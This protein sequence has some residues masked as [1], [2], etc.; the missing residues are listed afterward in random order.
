[1]TAG[2]EGVVHCFGLAA[3][4]QR[5]FT[6]DL[7]DIVLVRGEANDGVKSVPWLGRKAGVV[8]GLRGRILK[9]RGWISRNGAFDYGVL[10]ECKYTLTFI[11]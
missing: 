9:E 5:R 6:G 2:S 8:C 4:G 11:A 1:M 7:C 3:A 10:R